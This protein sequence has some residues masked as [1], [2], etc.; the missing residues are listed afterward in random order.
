MN[1]STRRLTE[2]ELLEWSAHVQGPVWGVR[3]ADRFGDSGLTGVL[4]VEF[5][6]GTASITDFILSC[7]VMG[8]RVEETM[9]HLAVD[10]ARRA[11]ALE[12]KANYTTT[13]KNQPCLEFFRRSGFRE[14][15]T[16]VFVWDTRSPY[17]ASPS[18]RVVRA[19][20]APAI[21]NGNTFPVAVGSK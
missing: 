8:R 18:I 1:L 4:A 17:E 11:G 5:G 13:P 12:V 14:T 10:C 20:E 19:D 9:L 3:V 6:H 2:A 15:S 16:G 21:E 7:R